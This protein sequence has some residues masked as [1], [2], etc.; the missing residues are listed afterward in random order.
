MALNGSIIK[1]AATGFTVTGGTDVTFS[2]DGTE[3]KNGMR[4]IDMSE[5]DFRVRPQLTVTS[6]QPTLIGNATYT[7]DK[8]T[9][10]LSIPKIL[11]DGT[12]VYNRIRV[13]REVHP[14]ATD[15]E[16]LELSYRLAQVLF[17][18]DFTNFWK[19]GQLL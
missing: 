2:D 7:R 6:K 18:S 17:D 8:R 9:A 19:F 3:V 4:L 13:E 16:A 10:T 15:A 5:S 12:T 14:E 11:A 1:K